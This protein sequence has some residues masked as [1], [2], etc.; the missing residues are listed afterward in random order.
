M[1]FKRSRVQI[2][3]PRLPQTPTVSQDAVGECTRL[4]APPAGPAPAYSRSTLIADGI[5]KFR[6]GGDPSQI[7]TPSW[8][9]T[10]AWTGQAIVLGLVAR[11]A[12]RKSLMILAPVAVVICLVGFRVVLN[13]WARPAA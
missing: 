10:A 1:G 2:S 12:P 8:R 3:S 4:A 9:P 11:R 6:T 7:D 5:V 13:T